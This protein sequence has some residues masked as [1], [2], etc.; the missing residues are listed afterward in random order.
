MRAT[1][2]K[3]H[4]SADHRLEITLPDDVPEGEA[5]I[6]V[7]SPEPCDTAAKQQDYLDAFF[8]DLENAA[9]PRRSKEDI[10]R[11]I[12]EERDNWY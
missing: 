2:L 10:D 7:L 6:I 9:V 3:A 8:M 5:E 11:L 1:K 12:Q 4:I